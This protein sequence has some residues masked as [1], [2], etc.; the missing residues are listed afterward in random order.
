[1]ENQEVLDEELEEISG[2]GLSLIVTGRQA[3]ALK[4]AGLIVNDEIDSSKLDDIHTFLSNKFE[5]SGP[6]NLKYYPE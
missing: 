5:I 3:R 6:L 2:G 4:D 1:M